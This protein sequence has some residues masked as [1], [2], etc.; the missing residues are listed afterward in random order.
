MEPEIQE[1]RLGS[2]TIRTDGF[3]GGWTDGRVHFHSDGVQKGNTDGSVCEEGT[4]MAFGMSPSGSQARGG[5]RKWSRGR[6]NEGWR[7]LDQM[8][9][10][11][12]GNR[13][14]S[15]SN[16]GPSLLA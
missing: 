8:L 7:L 12:G 6:C 4:G 3:R 2:L 15:S 16:T 14:F 13:A 9:A 5:Q 11:G 1:R 10:G